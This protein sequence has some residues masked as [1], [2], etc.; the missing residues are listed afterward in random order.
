MGLTQPA[1]NASHGNGAFKREDL[2]ALLDKLIAVRWDVNMVLHEGADAPP[3]MAK[4]LRRVD[5]KL[6]A[7]IAAL[8]MLF[9]D[10]GLPL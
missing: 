8:K 5:A 7:A 6:E 4:H 2:S 10:E 9:Q 3:E 1:V